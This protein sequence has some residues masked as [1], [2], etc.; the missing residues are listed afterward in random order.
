MSNSV[1]KKQ[2]KFANT[3]SFYSTLACCICVGLCFSILIKNNL[4]NAL[5]LICIIITAAARV[6][7]KKIDWFANVSKIIYMIIFSIAPPAVFYMLESAGSFGLPSIAFSFAYIF[8]ANMYYN[9]RIVWLYSGTT[10]LIYNIAIFAFPN[11][12]FTGPGKNLISWISFGIAFIVSV[13]VSTILSRR[14]RK[15]VLDIDN[16]KNESEKLTELLNQSISDASIRSEN[17]Y[18]VAKNLSDVINEFNKASDQTMASIIS[19]AEGSSMQHELTAKSFDVVS[20]ISNKLMSVAE[21]ISN[22]SAYARDC[23]GM[24]SEGNLI[25]SSAIEQIEL[26]D[27]N[28]TRLTNAMKLLAEKSAEIG[29]ITAMISTIAQQTNLLS[30]NASIEAARAGEAGKGFSV[31][32]SEIR[33]L[34]DQSRNATVKINNLINQV[35]IEI[36]NTAAITNESNHSVNEG[37]GIIKSAGEIFGKIYTSVNE[38]SSYSNTVSENVQ[39]LYNNSQNV[40]LSISEIKQAS[41][42]ISKSSADVAAVSKQQNATLEEINSIAGKLYHMSTELK[43]SIKLSSPQQANREA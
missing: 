29:Q 27:T 13:F 43:N 30:L 38:I 8:V 1:L 34:A 28:A 23:S 32:A 15:M 24:T 20:D 37:I 35:Q 12:F 4:I 33:S 9:H 3:I 2:E 16:K 18:R 10:I 19:I 41:K 22:V 6:L 11:E 17:L 39:D 31:V 21:S 40:V 36:E 25:I 7:E 5:F 26:I 14:S 42:E